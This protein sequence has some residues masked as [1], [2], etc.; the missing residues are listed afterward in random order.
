MKC[1]NCGEEALS[2][3][4]MQRQEEIVNLAREM[5]ADLETRKEEHGRLWEELGL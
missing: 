1:H 4:E 2:P 5:L 3:E